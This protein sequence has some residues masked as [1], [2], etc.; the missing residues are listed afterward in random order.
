MYVRCSSS[1]ILET[2]AKRRS[3]LFRILEIDFTQAVEQ[4]TELLGADCSIPLTAT[5]PKGPPT[6]TTY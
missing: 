2:P 5:C 4:Q 6:P 3:V 1:V